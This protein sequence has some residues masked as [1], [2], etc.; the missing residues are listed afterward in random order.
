MGNPESR[1]S[2]GED[3]QS[4]AH[5]GDRHAEETR[6]PRRSSQ[7]AGKDPGRPSPSAEA[8]APEED[9]VPRPAAQS[10]QRQRP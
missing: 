4:G 5:G 3:R 6:E 1:P 7:A 10:G 9:R 2:P 8:V